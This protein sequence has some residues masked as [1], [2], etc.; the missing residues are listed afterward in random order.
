MKKMNHYTKLSYI[1][2][3]RGICGYVLYRGQKLLSSIETIT[4]LLIC[5]VP[6]S[7]LNVLYFC[8]LK[9]LDSLKVPE[10][11]EVLPANEIFLNICSPSDNFRVCLLHGND[12]LAK[13]LSSSL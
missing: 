12:S 2:G 7:L 1:D 10:T 9:L 13:L 11:V 8:S 3:E 6:F 5:D 4:L